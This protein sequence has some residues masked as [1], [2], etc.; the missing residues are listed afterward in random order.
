MRVAPE[1]GTVLIDVDETNAINDS[2]LIEGDQATIC[3]DN[4]PSPVAV[5]K[6]GYETNLSYRYVITDESDTI[7]AITDTNAI[8]LSG[9]GVGICR[10]WGWSYRGTPSNGSGF[11]GGPVADLDAVNCSDI[12][13]NFI[14]I[15]RV[16]GED[17]NS[18]SVN[19][20]DEGISFNVYPNPVVDKL[21]IR[22]NNNNISDE[23]VVD[24]FNINGQ[25]VLSKTVSNTDTLIDLT[26]LER[27]IYLM[28]LNASSRGVLSTTKIIKN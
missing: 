23:M 27:G 3:V 19:D 26:S 17:C 4:G 9:A 18:L 22:I 11:I 21:N 13:D 16:T 12:S 1:A 20:F 8:D 28:R 5:S 14:T 24:L 25:R 2:V 7:L 15:I 10:I 6:T